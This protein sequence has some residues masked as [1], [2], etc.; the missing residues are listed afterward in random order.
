M[1]ELFHDGGLHSAPLN[2]GGDFLVLKKK[3]CGGL[4]KIGCEEEHSTFKS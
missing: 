2:Y 1:G 3:F 4:A